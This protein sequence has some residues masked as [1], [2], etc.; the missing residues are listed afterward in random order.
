MGGYGSGR[1][2]RGDTKAKVEDCRSIDANNLARWGYL[3]PGGPPA[4]ILRWMRGEY[5]AG[6]CNF[7]VRMDDASPSITFKYKYNDQDH[8]DVKVYLSSYSPGFGGRRYLFICPHC[9]RRMRTLHIR[10]GEIA[11]RLCHR[12]TYESCVENHKFD[13]LFKYM[14]RRYN[15]YSWETYKKTFNRQL[16]A[17]KYG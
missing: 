3:H 5:Q 2:Y 11:C 14:A 9:Q 4:G 8:P 16:K 12:L 6:A 7:S 13:A 17:T 10:G 15:D 1:Y